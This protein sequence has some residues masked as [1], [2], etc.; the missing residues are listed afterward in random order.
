MLYR[1]L[2][3]D[4]NRAGITDI[5]RQYFCGF[6]KYAAQGVYTGI[7]EPALIIEID[8]LDCTAFDKVRLIAAEIKKLNDQECVLV[9]KIDC[10]S[11]FV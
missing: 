4:K 1:I 11:E 9:Q 8:S 10:K 3:E 7:T 2:T 5:V 6:T